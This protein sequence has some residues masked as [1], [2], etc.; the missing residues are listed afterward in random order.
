MRRHYLTA[1]IKLLR[2][3]RIGCSETAQYNIPKGKYQQSQVYS[4]SVFP[5]FMALEAL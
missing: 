3:Q 5:R 4:E 1:E 2:N